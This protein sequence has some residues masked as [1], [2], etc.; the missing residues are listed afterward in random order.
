MKCSLFDGLYFS[1]PLVNCYDGET[2]SGEG[3]GGDGGAAVAVATAAAAAGGAGGGNKMFTQDELNKLNAADRR[4]DREAMA[5]LEQQLAGLKENVNLSDKDK[6]DLEANLEMVRGQLRTKED[7]AKHEKKKLEEELTGKIK[8][9]EG[10]YGELEGRYR[11]E[12]VKRSWQDAFGSDAFNLQQ[13]VAMMSS[14]SKLVPV[15]DEKTKQATGESKIVVELDDEDADG[16]PTKSTL[17]P[18]E[19]VKRMKELKHKYG[20]LFKTNVVA[21]VGG[22]NTTGGL[23]GKG[24]IDLKKL[25]SDPEQYRK[26]RKEQPEALYSKR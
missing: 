3:E 1:R 20:Y 4:K 17:T 21:G 9:L 5:K 10:R 25:A 18:A 8:D 23:S 2:G 14:Q 12:T 19:A 26:M 16:N 7:Q 15:I 11:S 24:E 22:S 13:S 6:A